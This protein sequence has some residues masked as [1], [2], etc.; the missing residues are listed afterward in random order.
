VTQ[1]FIESEDG[2]GDLG[3]DAAQIIPIIDLEVTA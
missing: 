1:T 3:L 2:P